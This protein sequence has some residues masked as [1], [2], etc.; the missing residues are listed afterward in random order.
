M[1]RTRALTHTFIAG[2]NVKWHG[3]SEKMVRQFLLKLKMHLSYD[4]ENA[5]LGFYTGKV[6]T[7]FYTEYFT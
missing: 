3:L 4:P 5:I 7:Y 6:K 1:N 2:D